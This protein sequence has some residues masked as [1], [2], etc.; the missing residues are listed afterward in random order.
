LPTDT[1]RF[2]ISP[3]WPRCGTTSLHDA[4][5]AGNRVAHYSQ[6]EIHAFTNKSVSRPEYFARFDVNP[7]APWAID[8]SPSYILGGRSVADRICATLGD[9]AY[10]LLSTREP[11]AC[12]W[13]FYI[14]SVIDDIV[15]PSLFYLKDPQ[16]GI[17][18]FYQPFMSEHSLRRVFSNTAGMARSFVDVFG[19]DK[20]ALARLEVEIKNGA[21][22]QSTVD[23]LVGPK[24]FSMGGEIPQSNAS[25][26][27]PWFFWGG[28]GGRVLETDQGRWLVPARSL[29]LINGVDDQL[30]PDFPRSVAL[31]LVAATQSLSRRL[32]ATSAKT[33]YQQ[34][35][36]QDHEALYAMFGYNPPAYSFRDRVE[37]MAALTKEMEAQLLPLSDD[38]ENISVGARTSTQIRSFEALGFNSDHR[39]LLEDA[40]ANDRPT[41]LLVASISLEHRNPVEA[42]ALI[43][44]AA[45]IEPLNPRHRSFAAVLAERQ[46]DHASMEGHAIAWSSECPMTDFPYIFLDLALR[47]KGA[48]SGPIDDKPLEVA[49]AAFLRH[50]ANGTPPLDAAWLAGLEARGQKPYQS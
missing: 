15:T 45:A 36:Q 41:A 24:Q 42:R 16:G 34:V 31:E 33:L 32:S 44:R 3:G 25:I 28:D 29:L 30:W 17:F 14:K 18:P 21:L 11:V 9:R 20:V 37:P 35:F 47:L 40:I 1:T 7:G 39:E 43:E 5:V 13:S 10:F 26:G 4:F 19:R 6:K 8:C 27:M 48:L 50:R 46:G 2:L 22:L 49:K 38:V 23:R 12:A